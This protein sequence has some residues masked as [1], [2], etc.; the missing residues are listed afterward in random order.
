MPGPLSLG[1]PELGPLQSM[2]WME[3]H[4][5]FTGASKGCFPQPD[6]LPSLQLQ[7][8]TAAQSQK[9]PCMFRSK[10]SLIQVSHLQ[11]R[12]TVDV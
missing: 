2:H 1:T 12:P 11:H 4:L 9:Q 8:F 5:K 3:C 6:R 10:R 7:L